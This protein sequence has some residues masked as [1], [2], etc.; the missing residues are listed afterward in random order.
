MKYIRTYFVGPTDT[1]GSRIGVTDDDGHR[2]FVPIDH[3]WSRP[4]REAVKIFC[5]RMGWRGTLTEGSSNRGYV[6]VFDDGWR[7]RFEA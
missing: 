3:S 6:Y 7:N 2:M 5:S 4:H 1:K